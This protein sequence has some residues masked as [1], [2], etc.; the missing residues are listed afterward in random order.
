MPEFAHH[1][2][3]RAAKDLD[4]LSVGPAV[5]L[6][7][8]DADYDA[9]AVH[10]LS[11]RIARYID[12]ALQ[13]VDGMIGDE[14]PIAVAMHVEPAHGVFAAEA[15]DDEMPGFY[16]HKLTALSQA[17]ESRLQLLAVGPARAKLTNQL[18]KRGARMRQAR[19]V[20]QDGGVG[21]LEQL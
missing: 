18:L 20:I 21:H 3:V 8:S 1:G 12:V 11:R 5:A 6:D 10:G 4:D 17:V 9:V 7:A 15:G 16:L 14:E 19:N 13:P 2:L